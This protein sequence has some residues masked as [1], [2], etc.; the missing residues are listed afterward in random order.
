MGRLSAAVSTILLGDSSSL[1]YSD[2]VIITSCE[3]N[4]KWNA[5]KIDQLHSR[6][7]ERSSNWTVPVSYTDTWCHFFCKKWN[8]HIRLVRTLDCSVK[9]NSH[10]TAIMNSSTKRRKFCPCQTNSVFLIHSFTSNEIWKC[11][12]KI[13]NVFIRKELLSFLVLI[14]ESFREIVRI[15]IVTRS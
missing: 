13:N 10:T 3:R 6:L 14:L 15:S 2:Y 5:C 9:T 1:T 12:Q 11:S 8:S 4:W 7:T